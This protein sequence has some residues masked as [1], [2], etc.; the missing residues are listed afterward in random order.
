M[1]FKLYVLK[2]SQPAGNHHLFWINLLSTG[3]TPCQISNFENKSVAQV[4]LGGEPESEDES[5]QIL[6]SDE[7]EVAP[8]AKKAKPSAPAKASASR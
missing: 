6:S 4:D 5:V 3:R 7:E 1:Y 2:I 8:A